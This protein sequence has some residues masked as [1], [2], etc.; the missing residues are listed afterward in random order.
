[1]FVPARRATSHRLALWA[2]LLLAAC[3]LALPA[4]ATAA[5]TGSIRGH[6]T[7]ASTHSALGGTQVIVFDSSGGWIASTQ[8]AAD[9]SYS[10]GL[11]PGS[12]ILE[13]SPL[14]GRHLS[15]YYDD[16]PTQ[17]AA[18]LVTVTAG[19]STT[20]V[21]AALAA[22]GQISG[23]VTDGATGL[24]VPSVYVNVYD[25]SSTWVTQT[26]TDSR[27]RYTIGDLPT[28]SYRVGFAPDDRQPYARQWASGRRTL[29]SADAIAVTAGSTTSGIDAHL[30]AQS[31]ITGTV[32]DGA[33]HQ[34][35][36][37]ALVT[38]YD[39]AGNFVGSA[40]ANREGEYAVGGLA[41]GS[42]RVGFMSDFGTANWAPQYFSGRATLQAA[43]PVAVSAGHP[44]VADAALTVG[45]RIQGTI[46]DATT[47]QPI[48][49]AWVD[50]L[51]ATGDVVAWAE[52]DGQGH[53]T[54]Q[55]LASG[56]F[57]LA[58]T[59]FD[60]VHAT[61]FY[62]GRVTLA[63]ADPVA[64][65]AGQTRTGI[66]EALPSGGAIA[67]SVTDAA[68]GRPVA[69][70]SVTVYDA[71]GGERAD[72]STAADGTYHLGG[73]A[74]GSYRVRVEG[75]TSYLADSYTS[76][77]YGGLTLASATSVSVTL[78]H[79]AGGVDVG[80]TGGGRVAGTVTRAT[81]HTPVAGATVS[82]AYHGST[83]ADWTATTAAD[84]SYVVGGIPS[85][86][87]DVRF[88][89]PSSNLT[90][91]AYDDRPS[92]GFADAVTVDAGTTTTG[93]DAALADGGA[94]AGTVTDA[95]TH[96]AVPG[97][98]VTA[99]A[100]DDTPVRTTTTAAN[101]AYT[102]GGLSPG[103]YRVGFAAPAGSDLLTQYD[104]GATTL[105]AAR[106]VTAP[107]GSTTRGV[108]AALAAGAAIAGTVTAATGGKPVA[109][110]E[111]LLY[112]ASGSLVEWT[113]TDDHGA[114][115]FHGLAP[116]RYRV[117]FSAS[118]YLQRFYDGAATLG[119]ATPVAATAGQTVANV[120]AALPDGG[121]IRG[122]VTDAALDAPIG[123]VTVTAYDASTEAA[124]ST[125]TTDAAGRYRLRG[126]PGGAYRVGYSAEDF[127]FGPPA[128]YVPQYYPAAATL[129]AGSTVSVTT[130]QTTAGIDTA[131]QQGGDVEGTV[132]NAT[133]HAPAA[134]VAVTIYDAAG[135]NV[136][137]AT[138]SSDGGYAVPGL[139]SGQYRVRF[140]TAYGS[141]Y[142]VEYYDDASSLSSAT[143]VGVSAGARTTGIDAALTPSGSI[144]GMV[145]DGQTGQ[146][147]PNV[148]VYAQ[149]SSGP[150]YAYGFSD[151][152]GHYELSG[153]TTGSYTVR[154]YALPS[155][156]YVST[157]YAHN[158]VSV[159][160][161]QATAG[162][163]I[164]LQP[165]AHISGT[166]TDATT[167]AP[168]GKV[169]VAAQGTSGDVLY[170]TATSRNDGT[171][172]IG[173]LPAGTYKVQFGAPG[174]TANYRPSYYDGKGSYASADTV[175]LTTGQH[176]SSVDGALQLGG[177][178]DGTVTDAGTAHPISG[179]SVSVYDNAGGY[180]GSTWTRPDGTYAL[181]GFAPGQYRVAFSA[182]AYTSQ[183]YDGKASIDQATVVTVTTGAATRGIDAAMS[184]GA[185]IRGTVTD[186]ATGSPLSGTIV[187]AESTNGSWLAGAATDSQGHY[188]LTGLPAGTVIV[189][190]LSDG[191]HFD[192]YYDGQTSA[193]DAA[194]LTVSTGQ[195]T[196][197]IDAALDVGGAIRGTVS[198]ADTGQ[199]LAH[200]SVYA[201]PEGGGTT[202]YG[203]TDSE[204][205]YTVGG[206]DTGTYQLS[207]RPYQNQ[208]YVAAAYPSDVSVTSGQATTGIDQALE[209][210]GQVS[211]TVS[212]ASTG[213]PLVGIGVSGVASAGDFLAFTNTVTDDQGHYTVAGL[214]SGA[215]TI[216]AYD[217]TGYHAQ[218]FT[219][220]GAVTVT[221]G[222]TLGGI[223]LALTPTGVLSGTV[224]TRDTSAP[225]NGAGVKLYDS[226]DALVRSTSTGS[227]G[228]FRFAELAAG[229]YRVAFD[230]GSTQAD[231]GTI[232]YD[233]KATL[234]DADPIAVT[235]GHTTSGIDGALFGPPV[236]Q[237][238]PTIAGTA[239]QGE[240]LT[241]HPGTWTQL[242][243]SYAYQW[244]RCPM[245]DV[246][247]AIPDATA[248]TY[249]LT[250]DDALSTIEVQEVARN[251]AGAGS[252]ATSNPT[253]S[254]LPLPPANTRAPAISGTAQQG[255]TLTA[256][257]GTWSN[258]P[259]SYARHWQ[260]CDTAGANCT[261]IS[262]ATGTT[263]VPVAADVG[264]TLVL[265]VTATNAG[266][267]SPATA[268]AATPVVVPPIPT[269]VTAPAIAGTAVQGQ[270]LSEQHGS[271]TNQPTS[272]AY[273]WQRCGA[274]GG[275]CLSIAGATGNTYTPVAAD[276]GATL[277]VT[278]TAT[279]AGGSS[280]PATSAVT[281]V[282]TAA[283]PINTNAPSIGGTAQQ[284]QTLTEQ[285]GSWT[286]QPT[287]YAY[288]WQRCDTAGANCTA[289]AG[290]TGGTYTPVA[291]DV[292]KTVRVTE[293]ASNAGGASLPAASSPTAVVVPPV[294]A[295]VT[296]P[297]IAGPARQGDTLT[298]G[299]GAWT[300][301]PTSYGYFWERCTAL[302]VSCVGIPGAS[303]GTYV[304]VAD[305][306]GATLRVT[307]V[308]QNDGGTSAPSSSAVTAIV[309]GA[310]PVNIAPPAVSGLAR[311]GETLTA[312]DGDWTNQPT[313]ATH[314][315]L[316][317]DAAG[318][319][320]TTISGATDTSYVAAA[321]DVG[322]TLRD[323]ATA[324]NVS[325]ASAPATSDPTAV[326]APPV[327]Q[328]TSAP[329]I[330]GTTQ[331]GQ[332]LTVHHGSWTGAPTTYD[333]QWERCDPLGALCLAI[334]GA[335]GST[336][337]PTAAD[338][339][340]TLRVTE[341]ATND[342][343][344]SDPSS[345]G[346]TTVIL[347]APPANLA[348]PTITGVAQQGQPLTAHDGSWTNEPTSHAFAWQR[349]D[350]AGL[351]CT[352]ISG[353]TSGTYTPGAADVGSTVR[354]AETA[355]NSGGTS[356]PTSSAATAKV[357]PPVPTNTSAP[358]ISGIAQQGEMLTEQHGSWTNGPTSYTHQWQRCDG[359]DCADIGGAT[360]RSYTA[361]T[362][363][364]G[365]TLRVA[366]S[367]SNGGVPSA[368]A[369]SAPTAAIT[370][371]PL[372]AVA[373]EATTVGVGTPVTLNGSGSSP[374]G[375]I[376][377]YAWDFGDQASGTGA[378]A[379]HTYATPGTYT[380][381]LTIA[382]AGHTAQA[383]TTVTVV[384][385]TAGAHVTVR[386]S[387]G[388]L[389]PG[390][391]LVYVGADGHRTTAVSGSDGVGTLPGLP[392]G[393]AAVNVWKSGF[394][395]VVVTVDVSGGNGSATATLTLGELATTTLTSRPMTLDEIL[396]AGIDVSDPA[397]Q[398]VYTFSIHLA[399]PAP[400]DGTRTME[401]CGY[402]N[403]EGEFVGATGFGC[404]GGGG[405]GSGGGGGGCSAS[406][407][408]HGP[409]VATGMVVE[410]HPLIT[411]LVLQGQ[412]TTLKQ[413]FSVNLVV[414][415]LSEEP[416]ELSD[417]SA[418]LDIPPGLSLA[419]TATSQNL[420]Q[421]VPTIPGRGSATTAWIVRGDTPG[422]YG[423]TASYHGR[424][425]PFDAPVDLS[426]TLADP[427]HVWGAEALGLKVQADSGTLK[428]G[429]PYHVRIGVANRADV[430]FY[431]VS[432]GVD[433]STHDQFI[434][435]PD[436]HFSDS[437]GEL[438]AGRTVYGHAYVLVPDADSAGAFDPQLS[439]AS[440]DGQ[441]VRE[442]EGI[443]AVA[444]PKLYDL[445][446]PTDTVGD[447]HLHWES[448]PGASGYRV[449]SIPDL[450]TPFEAAP[451]SVQDF[452]GEQVTTLPASANDAFIPVGADSARYY[453]VSS[454]IAG[455]STL[456]HPV[457]VG[458]P[459]V[460]PPDGGGGSGVG[461]GSG[462]GSGGGGRA[463][464]GSE[465]GVGV[466]TPTPGCALSKVLV[467][468]VTIQAACFVK[469]AKGVLQARGH[470]RVGG[471]DVTSTGGFT[472]DPL[473]LSLT[474]SG[475]ADVYA[476]TLHLY[477]GDV[478]WHVQVHKSEEWKVPN[479]LQIKGLP[480]AGSIEADFTTT[481]VQATARASIGNAQ[482]SFAVTGEVHL[483]AT[484][485]DGLKLDKLKLELDSDLK[486]QSLVVKQASLTYERTSGGDRWTGQVG[487]DL[488]SGPEITGKLVL[489]KGAVAEV[490]I[491]ADK[492]NKPLG[493][494]IFLQSLG[495][496][497]LLKPSFKATGSIGLTAGPK[498]LGV[499]AAQLDASLSVQFQPHFV[500]SANGT[501]KVVE[502]SVS[503]ASLTAQVPGGVS[504]SGDMQRGFAGFTVT[505]HIGGSV[506]SR[507]FEAQGGASVD[508]PGASGHGKALV[509][510]QGVAAC[511]DLQTDFLHQSFTVGGG[512]NW[513]SRHNGLLDG[514]CGF[515]ELKQ[516]I[517]HLASVEAHAA[518]A[519]DVP[520][521]SVGKQLNLIVQGSGGAPTVVLTHGSESVTVAPGTSG[522]FAE[523]EYVALSDPEGSRTGII[524]PRAPAGSVS[525]APVA[526][527]APVSVTTTAL[528]PSPNVHV[529]VRAL[530]HRRYRLTWA[531]RRIAGQQLVLREIAG[532]AST[533]LRATTAARGELTF[534]ALTTPT[535]AH[536]IQVVVDQDGTPREILSSA[537][538]FR[539]AQPRL[540]RPRV[541]IAR[542]GA[543]ATIRWS[544]GRDVDHYEI[545]VTTSDGRRLFFSRPRSVHS[546]VIPTA[547]KIRASVRAIG[548]TQAAGPAGRATS[549]RR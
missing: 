133:T 91:E 410:G 59:P 72:G 473:A 191:V 355:T 489:L 298:A 503:S 515:A 366:E 507:H 305:D 427:L 539:V 320:C 165:A 315:W 396:A 140:A 13:F 216:S 47:H 82:V 260:R 181:H 227:D 364:I 486:V 509:D 465:Q 6:V 254:V 299:T 293:T 128:L 38:A 445:Q 262:G 440:F 195:T 544:R 149:T 77:W 167:H 361:A 400:V 42:Y 224:T 282:V 549:R 215:A 518:L 263:Y 435:Q 145:T 192:E 251:A 70:A 541:R 29:D 432:I 484:P 250:N 111:V 37:Y 223:N 226:T 44:A 421:S 494:V 505:S 30:V 120:D 311:Q 112:D 9:G 201:S 390:A 504:F 296:A 398:N 98:T 242:P 76:R 247:F 461:G 338:V 113:W 110:S 51:D 467:G 148:Q 49:D 284:G 218:T 126:L 207:F 511:A 259:T 256:S 480:V 324:S 141:R 333:E 46:T 107:A 475:T 229:S 139:A 228:R 205:R 273:Q 74:A 198:A 41:D 448:V 116:G 500:L 319:A 134:G 426:A 177:E 352:A 182:Y 460:A 520:A 517:A 468:G 52:V 436:E 105:D 194:Q 62:H 158:P 220:S 379:Q 102:L 498:I 79:T 301:A 347:P 210:G 317:C 143:Q 162:I 84:G 212:D 411:W 103:Q 276:V 267:S 485:T 444:P 291:A 418:T 61:S 86:S 253:A 200:V 496:D 459:G 303:S 455:H 378:I 36:A 302:G 534:T 358:T 528:L 92:S 88:A 326:V 357:L 376:E 312:D 371:P 362:A 463:S 470:I 351:Q 404:S 348:A 482:S 288:Q 415:N 447:V 458:R 491:R 393:K 138:T 249:T 240:V 245:A 450:D 115:A 437:V 153:L 372:R 246:C 48:A 208:N 20:N 96:A 392:D 252:P 300:N 75:P 331:Q 10:V 222:S 341:T 114:Y 369:A 380:A 318:G 516:T 471:L 407:C 243:D 97:T 526:G 512:H 170:A 327:P 199:G 290:A 33:A 235:T 536:R 422:F 506:D 3:C 248:T 189:H 179:A 178:I 508:V 25:S 438:P 94:L 441:P 166:L 28:G 304:P 168:A 150:S 69:G 154:T 469:N 136:G 514:A 501:L 26:R 53:Y 405:G 172:D 387:G 330:T 27:G 367:A 456:E 269:I 5:G 546:L 50:A 386:D 439:T 446:A 93:I 322:G 499:A 406:S 129:P 275:S 329:T 370:I 519:V 21:D 95:A 307:V 457:V 383:T 241:A 85:G 109:Y 548:A 71:T 323:R 346:T 531:A 334:G 34:P 196:T 146:P 268:S 108:D 342:G 2:S 127:D 57:R 294:P 125:T 169:A 543:T 429:R 395:P 349:C 423:L 540:A 40:Q 363:D 16:Q 4:D 417:G 58:V 156:D 68:S 244:L 130:G 123:G 525:V 545:T 412:V 328:P 314:Q 203:S 7:D 180:V 478:A 360:G 345:S 265:S 389:L 521:A 175:T 32:T 15:E 289:I 287:S 495:L 118:G 67:G 164:A 104:G 403:S 453:A 483:Q 89:A 185:T 152:S 374:A 100:A 217:G 232:Y 336:Y 80:L 283:P 297:A 497:V 537:A 173:G 225:V 66:D 270:A 124:V 39:S 337:V 258:R 476:G 472:I 350:A 384:R 533:T 81:T 83:Y 17:T 11:A 477:H 524:L 213:D 239:K 309:V 368:R 295:I 280:T 464:G 65:T 353:A 510:D 54:L 381:K 131:L 160:L 308:A 481:G 382:D 106:S 135:T 292:G 261:A 231:Y 356:A 375:V 99:Y 487:V 147:V 433:P 277:R 402:I 449:F 532:G 281:A 399:F 428:A 187:H 161:G 151:A 413:F 344:T 119:A 466:P 419:P 513:R 144:A 321:A 137:S 522:R 442:G 73:L 121:A 63:G 219:A 424:L 22:A 117:G 492:I 538:T 430:P 365:H 310:A 443:E 183:F 385:Q 202:M 388:N 90:D 237:S 359:A 174:G 214:P 272:Y 462:G 452:G 221:A 529:K 234:A 451:D 238:P 31:V 190:F 122:T 416:F 19:Q 454:I 285:H 255:K 56:S 266:G 35:A 335:S 101:G 197:G 408:T 354:V 64:V 206:L 502:L 434:F 431:N 397:N 23:T 339:G 132:T 391:S 60:Q 278:E 530:G 193:A 184:T 527:G 211:G 271:W 264:S 535:A 425:Q 340:A 204:G 313:S 316:R 159:T 188:A 233:G 163:D 414:D 547:R 171:Y 490:G 1:M 18:N 55:G 488:P 343:G 479:G 279:N 286:N 230:A 409:V 373:G 176:L 420:T 274:L 377:S 43:D 257:D 474:S 14:D 12:Y 78:A 332:T 523:T 542:P 142:V 87:Y 306:V 493:E 155:Q 186:A 394:Q 157:S 401:F 209:V 236:N 24:P 45:G 8:A 325:G